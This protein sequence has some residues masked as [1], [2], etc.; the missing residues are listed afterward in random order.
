MEGLKMDEIKKLNEWN[1]VG[2]NLYLGSEIIQKLG[3]R[4]FQDLTA[5]G[6][7]EKTSILAP[8]NNVYRFK[9]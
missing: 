1:G 8:G 3:Y 5:S 2:S 6:R 7:M 9:Q 4:K